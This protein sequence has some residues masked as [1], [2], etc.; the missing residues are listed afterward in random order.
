[1]NIPDFKMNYN[2]SDATK[3]LNELKKILE[4]INKE[5]EK[6]EKLKE[7]IININ[8]SVTEVKKKWWRFWD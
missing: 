7:I 8:F 6:L 3:K 1:M 4:K 5:T 2:N